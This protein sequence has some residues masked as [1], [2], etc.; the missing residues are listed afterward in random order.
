MSSILKAA[1][2]GIIIF[3]VTILLLVPVALVFAGQD[4]VASTVIPIEEKARNVDSITH[5]TGLPL[6]AEGDP[7]EFYHF[8]DNYNW[9][10]S[11][12]P[13]TCE[14]CFIGYKNRICDEEL[15]NEM[16]EFDGGD[17]EIA[18]CDYSVNDCLNNPLHQQG[19][20]SKFL[21]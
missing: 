1:M 16:C 11:D 2:L 14:T 6:E 19:L 10:K 3:C 8:N 12:C 21:V 20:I 9:S 13:G 5:Y 18:F 7:L 17:C 15:N 4:D